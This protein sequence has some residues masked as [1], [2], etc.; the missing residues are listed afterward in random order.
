LRLLGEGPSSTSVRIAW[1]LFRRLGRPR[2][3]GT[4]LAIASLLVACSAA[5][6]PPPP[7]PP[8]TPP[9]AAQPRAPDFADKAL[10]EWIGARLPKGGALVAR[11][12][13]TIGIAHTVQVA[14]S[15]GNVAEAY[16]D[17]TDVYTAGDLESAILEVNGLA[18][19]EPTAPGKT[20][21]IPDV[22]AALPKSP[23]PLGWPEDKAL[24]GV[25]VRAH[26]AARQGFLPL[27]D[28]MAAR[29][30]N[31]VV[32]DV[33]DADGRITY[34]SAVPLAIEIGAV[35]HPAIRSLA[36]TI[37]FA[38]AR[39]IRVSMR[40]VCFADD[41]LSRRRPDF[42]VQSILKRPLRVGWLDP[43][44]DGVQKYVLD[45]A[46]EAIDAG[47]DE[48]QLDYV[49]YPVQEARH[50]DFRAT[51]K[52][53]SRP[54]VIAR[55]ARRVHELAQARGVALVVDIFGI[56]AENV[57]T[58]IANLGQSPVM[59]ARE[60]EAL[61]PMVY[62][63]HYPKGFLGF[64][65][66]GA[67]PELVRIGVGHL[68][69]MTRAIR[70]NTG[71]VIRP[72]IQGMPYHAPSFGPGYVAEQI[73]HARKAGAAGWMVWNPTQDYGATWRAVA[74]TGQDVAENGGPPGRRARLP[75]PAPHR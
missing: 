30:M 46:A 50:A 22:V 28:Q 70:R 13:G 52:G 65:E 49:R 73:G 20:L 58:D 12:D 33:K 21:S 18:G 56:V 29:G 32:L 7:P 60:C 61:A 26:S 31:L 62:P 43:A 44:S 47:A 15:V 14:Q 24:R 8:K 69:E 74:P 48:I 35:K 37:A 5:R 57:K 25:H 38:H 68:V 54:E 39:G 53:L 16:L 17:L 42:A 4:A 51:Q 66:P 19:A 55:F 23:A 41:T 6:V 72:W 75:S 1:P 34:P 27:L 64:Q 10:A 9:V 11:A 40:I 45:L 36:R 71:T 3:T 59:L 63:S 67:H 2:P